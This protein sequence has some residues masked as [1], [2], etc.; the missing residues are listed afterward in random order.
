MVSYKNGVL[1]LSSERDEDGGIVQIIKKIY[2][3]VFVLSLFILY[4]FAFV[5]LVS[6][7]VAGALLATALLIL[8]FRKKP[9]ISVPYNFIWYFVLTVYCALSTLWSTYYSTNI[10]GTLLR[11]AV[12]C[13]LI[14]SITI[15]VDTQEDLERLISLFI[16]G[17]SFICLYEF[18]ATPVENWTT[19]L[20]GGNLPGNNSNEIA[21][22]AACAEMMAFYKAYIKEK[23]SYYIPVLF[24]ITFV[25]LSSSR[26]AVLMSLIAPMGIMLLATYK[27]NYLF[28]IIGI[29]LS[30]F[31]VFYLI[32][33]N[34]T[35]YNI[36]GIRMKGLSE[37]LL[38]KDDY[39]TSL[40]LR[41]YFISVGKKLFVSSPLV[42]RGFG[43]FSHLLGENPSSEY[44]NFGG[45]YAH[46][47]YWQ[48]LSELGLV[49][50]I[51]YYSMYALIIF[52]LAKR[53]FVERDR[54]SYLFLVFIVVLMIFESG[55]VSL[56]S[57]YCQ[58]VIA[59]AYACTFATNKNQITID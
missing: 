47:N 24:F 2:G 15:Y 36:I 38:K 14:T 16:L 12:I 21:F 23:K 51:I 35:L 49:G 42:G 40:F 52:K 18:Y 26:K 8:L 17:V 50:F 34:E 30:V 46:N 27:P 48:I 3:I 28:R 31:F 32:F 45:T 37:F 41:Q 7:F 44:L 6:T 53:V 11:M 20:L 43:N 39:D 10:T 5:K 25:L 57:K 22:W 1:R 4:R 29:L 33:T 19:G 58:Y 55:I 13:M 9:N 54:L 59:L 56:Y